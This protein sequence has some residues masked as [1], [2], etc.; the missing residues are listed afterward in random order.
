MS[1]ISIISTATGRVWEGESA[2][3]VDL[4]GMEALFR[5]F[6]RVDEGDNERLE[7]L[8]YDLPSLSSGDFVCVNDGEDAWWLC[9]NV[10]WQRVT[11]RQAVLPAL[12][13]QS[14]QALAPSQG[15]YAAEVRPPMF[16]KVED[17]GALV[18]MTPDSRWRRIPV[19]GPTEWVER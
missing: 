18:Y 13:Y 4:D 3:D 17:D 11:P 9:A 1:K 14:A 5:E 10:G 12:D 16:L 19:Q 6:N 15:R 7:A 2:T 8:G